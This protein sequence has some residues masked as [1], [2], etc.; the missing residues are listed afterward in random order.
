[1]TF[2][3]DLLFYLFLFFLLFLIICLHVSLKCCFRLKKL[4]NRGYEDM[5]AD[6]KSNIQLCPASRNVCLQGQNDIKNSN[7]TV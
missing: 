2:P 1:M 5:R 3:S 4:L 6:P 7:K